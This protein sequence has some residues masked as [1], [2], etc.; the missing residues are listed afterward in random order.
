MRSTIEIFS[1]FSQGIE[2]MSDDYGFFPTREDGWVHHA[3][4]VEPGS[5]A[6]VYQVEIPEGDE[7]I[8]GAT[9][10]VALSSPVTVLN[11]GDTVYIAEE[12]IEDDRTGFANYPQVFLVKQV[13]H[14]LYN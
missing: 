7:E 8:E 9:E 5:E 3:T 11:V 14:T 13:G 2:T 12:Y 1:P 10:V 6:V 4:V